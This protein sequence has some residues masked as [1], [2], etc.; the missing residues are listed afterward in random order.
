MET[1]MGKPIKPKGMTDEA[2]LHWDNVVPVLVEMKVAKEIDTDAL[3]AL[4]DWWSDYKK[5]SDVDSELPEKIRIGL[6]NLSFNNWKGM[7]VKFGMSP[8]D[9]ANLVQPGAEKETLEDWL[10]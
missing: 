8:A 3:E 10:K 7:M 9:R 6:K 2:N 5:Y 1:A 4:C